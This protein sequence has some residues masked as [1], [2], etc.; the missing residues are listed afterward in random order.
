M[1]EWHVEHMQKTIIK[2]ISGISDTM[3]LLQA[4]QYMKYYNISNVQK[5]LYYD[6][7]HGVTKEDIFLFIEK[8]RTHP[9][10]YVLQSNKLAM[11]RLRNIE[12][13]VY[14]EYRIQER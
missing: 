9:S 3:S 11:E 2:Y 6:T 13:Y 8:V 5:T 14:S 10:Y 12:K 1:R 7:N 4:R